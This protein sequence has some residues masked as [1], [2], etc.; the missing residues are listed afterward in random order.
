[1]IMYYASDKMKSWAQSLSDSPVTSIVM[2][3]DPK[4]TV[5]TAKRDVRQRCTV[6][7]KDNVER[8]SALLHTRRR[9]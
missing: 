8:G 1:M 2:D 4:G 7:R 6:K 5:G 3:R 9:T